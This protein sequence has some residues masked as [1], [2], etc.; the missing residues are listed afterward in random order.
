MN[1]SKYRLL[2]V[3]GLSLIT[4][5]CGNSNEQ[6]E[7]ETLSTSLTEMSNS[8]EQSSK[9]YAPT[10]DEVLAKQ[11]EVLNGMSAEN[12]ETLKKLVKNANLSL[13]YD[14]FHGS[15]LTNMEDPDSLAWNY[16]KNTGEIHV[17]WSYDT[18]HLT[19]K[20]NYNLTDD[21]FN[22]KYGSKV[23][24]YNE[25]DG[26]TF[27]THMEEIKETIYNE[28]FKQDFDALIFNMQQAMDTHNV[29]YLYEIFKIFHDM[30]YYLLRYG[31][32]EMAQYV[33]DMSF[34][35]KYYGV[36]EVYK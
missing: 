34:V 11:A 28:T 27:I 33:S 12:I 2:F 13:E 35:E 9:T 20:D 29:D 1:T 17:G 32:T 36:L 30:D 19:Q 14:Y 4:L 10:E 8:S 24:A 31:P 25:I 15:V 16:I 3:L 26:A 22:Q 7:N 5:G 21:E 18:E 6:I 23:I